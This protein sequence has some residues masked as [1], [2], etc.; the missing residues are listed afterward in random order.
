MTFYEQ[1]FGEENK[2]LKSNTRIIRILGRD[3]K[4]SQYFA[5]GRRS[6]ELLIEDVELTFGM[7]AFGVDLL[8]NRKC[9]K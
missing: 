3:D 6:I 5:I 8:Q 4:S 2:G 9:N 1:M 7:P